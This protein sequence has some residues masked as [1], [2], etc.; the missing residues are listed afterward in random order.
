MHMILRIKKFIK[1][2]F[3]S[4]KNSNN[5][6]SHNDLIQHKRVQ[7]WF[8]INGDETLRLD[9]DLNSNS[10]VF[11]VGGYNGDFS[12]KIFCK[13]NSSIYIFEPVKKFYSNIE[14]RFSHNDKV[15]VFNFGLSSKDDELEI[16]LSNN[17]SSIYLNDVNSELVSLR[18]INYFIE[19]NKIKQ[20]DLIKINIEG[21][22]YELLESILTN[23]DIKMYNNIQVQFH[24][25]LFE[26]A[27]ER[28]NLIHEKLVKTHKLSYQYEFVWENWEL[29]K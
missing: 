4:N 17:A 20:V 7:P 3:K 27:K 11:D 21:G 23:G 15:K 16:S 19:K 12:S 29:I 14:K 2:C 22:E 1:N 6:I 26:N 9:Y 13:Y 8:K 18:S 24:D 28:M 25:F 10:I 5:K